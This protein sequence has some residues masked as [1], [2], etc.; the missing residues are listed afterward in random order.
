[1]CAVVGVHMR[2]ARAYGTPCTPCA[3]DRALADA[4]AVLVSD[5]GRGVAADPVVRAALARA[6]RRRVSVVWDPH[7][8]GA[9]PVPGVTVVTRPAPVWVRR[10]PS[11]RSSSSGWDVRAVAVTLGARGAAVRHRHGACAAAP[12]PAVAGTDPCGAGDHF[13]GSPRGS[14]PAR[15]STRP[16]PVRSRAPP[17][18]WRAA[19]EPRCAGSAMRGASPSAPSSVQRVE[20]AMALRVGAV[21]VD[22]DAG[23]GARP[24]YGGRVGCRQQEVDAPDALD[25]RGRRGARRQHEAMLRPPDPARP[26]ADRPGRIG[27]VRA[28]IVAG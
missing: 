19:G 26:R 2:V 21:Q 22:G 24:R 18:S 11:A 6:V 25:D 3:L 28:W 15:P 23:C 4:G 13:A 12:A 16:W 9:D 1:M 5:D 27:P 20:R 17:I 7:P 8:L 10:S 14:P